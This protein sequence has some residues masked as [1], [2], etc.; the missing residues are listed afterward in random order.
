MNAARDYQSNWIRDN[1]RG[2]SE[3][4]SLWYHVVA[5]VVRRSSAV[6]T[7]RY[8]TATVRTCD[9]WRRRYV[10]IRSSVN[11]RLTPSLSSSTCPNRPRTRTA[12]RVVSF[13][14]FTVVT[15][16]GILTHKARKYLVFS[17]PTLS[18]LGHLHRTDPSQDHYRALQA[19]IMGPPDDWKRM[20]GRPRQ[21]WL[22]TVEADLRPMN[23]GLA[24]S[25]RRVQVTSTWRKLI[26]TA[27][28]TTSSRRRRPLFDASAQGK[29]LEFLHETA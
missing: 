25:K 7:L 26:A 10:S 20:I 15:V 27:T 14:A 9:E 5:V 13:Q 28:S 18:F 29:P 16:Y 8:V 2:Q 6:V 23:L 1:D 22:R 19:C 3:K 24:T 11:T 4:S 17:H 12:R 21:S